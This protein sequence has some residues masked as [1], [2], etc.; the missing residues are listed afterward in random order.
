MADL[1]RINNDMNNLLSGTGIATIFVDHELQ[2][3]RFTPAATRIVN[4]IK[5]DVGRPVNHVV[6]NLKDYNNLAADTQSVL[7]TLTPREVEVQI[8][9]GTWYT[10]R[11]LPYR[12]QDNV[13]EGA[14]ITFSDITERKRAENEVKRQLSEKETLLREV[15]HRIKNNIS[16][17]GSLLSLHAQS[18]KI[19]EA[20]SA[21]QDAMGRI[22]SMKVLY[23]KL[24]PS[25]DYHDISVKSYTESLTTTIMALF[26]DIS[27][28]TVNRRIDE[29]LLD[30]KRLFPLGIII[31]ELLTNIMKYA[32]IGRD[33]GEVE[34]SLKK[35]GNHVTL[36]IQ[37]NGN[38]LPDAFDIEKSKGFGLML[39]NMLSQQLNGKFSIETQAGTRC[40]IEFDM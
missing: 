11:I 21:L 34:L 40:M 20:V 35:I 8:L 31:N 9:A 4:L 26:P 5:S 33:T 12:T 19:P 1:A 23:E 18:T 14:V 39:V 25:E 15:H 13:I 38:G 6:S 36:S 10:M 2:I 32:F 16:S 37:D 29:F 3:L 17:I 30:S 27:R 24:L 7:E 28:I 22:N